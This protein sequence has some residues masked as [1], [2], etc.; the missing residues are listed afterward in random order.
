MLSLRSTNVIVQYT[1]YL[2][3]VMFVY[4][5]GVV[6]KRKYSVLDFLQRTIKFD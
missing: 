2:I 6:S 4:V 5:V 3:S 1:Y